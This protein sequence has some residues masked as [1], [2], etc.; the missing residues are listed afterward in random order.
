[1]MPDRLLRR[2]RLLRIQPNDI[3]VVESAERLP[4][5]VRARL[6]DEAVRTFGPNR[7]AVLEGGI[8]LRVLRKQTRRPR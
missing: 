6:L 4:E 8:T 7:V 5:A 1:M 2:A 3:I